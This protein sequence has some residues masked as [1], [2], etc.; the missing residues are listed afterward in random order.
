MTLVTGT[1]MCCDSYYLGK[2]KGRRG[3]G[4][5]RRRDRR[6]E[7]TERSVYEMMVV[8]MVSSMFVK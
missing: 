2:R 7:G 1:R 5:K 8:A 6:K 3:E 4:K